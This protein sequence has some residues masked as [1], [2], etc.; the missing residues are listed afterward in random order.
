MNTE[1]EYSLYI[2]LCDQ[3]T[4]YTGIALCPEE[5]LK[6]HQLGHPFGAKFTRRFKQLEIIYQV[7]VGDRSQAQS[8]EIKMKKLSKKAK[9][10]VV[11]RQCKLPEL[12]TVL[13]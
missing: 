11:D 9:L 2:L 6:Q 13:N 10:T 7:K 4:L 3:K 8:I 12:L 1:T 5:R